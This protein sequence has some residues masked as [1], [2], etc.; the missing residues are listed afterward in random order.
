MYM[1]PVDAPFEVQKACLARFFPPN[2]KN[3]IFRFIPKKKTTA[4]L[5][6]VSKKRR[7]RDRYDSLLQLRLKYQFALSK[8]CGILRLGVPKLSTNI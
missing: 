4:A 8:T 7:Q 2:I 3:A 6:H 5:L 1:V